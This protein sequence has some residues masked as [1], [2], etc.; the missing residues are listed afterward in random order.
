MTI[1]TCCHIGLQVIT[2]NACPPLK[3]EAVQLFIKLATGWMDGRGSISVRR[4]GFRYDVT[5]TSEV[6][7]DSKVIVKKAPF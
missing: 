6:N 7:S 3:N 5:T 2:P 1:N 4:Q